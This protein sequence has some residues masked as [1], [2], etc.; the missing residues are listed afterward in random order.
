MCERCDALGAQF[1]A[2]KACDDKEHA[3]KVF[4]DLKSIATEWGIGIQL[5]EVDPDEDSQ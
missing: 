3:A 2:A 1:D 5:V 4:L